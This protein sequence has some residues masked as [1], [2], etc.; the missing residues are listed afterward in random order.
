M[1]RLPKHSESSGDIEYEVIEDEEEVMEWWSDT[2]VLEHQS[3]ELMPVSNDD[4]EGIEVTVAIDSGAVDHV[5]SG[6]D[7]HG[8]QVVP[9]A[10]SKAGKH[11][12]GA[13]GKTIENLGQAAVSMKAPTTGVRINSIFQI[14]HVSRPLY[15]VSRICDSGCEVTFNQSEGKVTKNGKLIAVFPRRGGLYVGTLMVKPAQPKDHEKMGFVRQA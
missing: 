7:L 6:E 13:N 14:A 1:R 10:S 3:V 12:M 15:S 5:A 9:S 4:P 11:F 8:I 2:C